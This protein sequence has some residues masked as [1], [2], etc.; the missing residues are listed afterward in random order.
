MDNSDEEINHL[1]LKYEIS[2]E[3]YQDQAPFHLDFCTFRNILEQ[4]NILERTMKI[5]IFLPLG[6]EELCSVF[7][8]VFANAR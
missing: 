1:S 7:P 8:G 4:L 5:I 3:G 2:Y 6:L